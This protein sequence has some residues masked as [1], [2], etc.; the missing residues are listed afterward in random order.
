MQKITYTSDKNDR[1]DSYLQ[2]RYP[3]LSFSKICKY[4]KENKIKVNGKKQPL[5]YRLQNNDEITLFINDL[6]DSTAPL[7]KFAKNE[8]SIQYEDENILIVNKPQGLICIDSNNTIADTLIN[9]VL[10]Y[11]NYDSSFAFTPALCHRLDT[12][13][14]GLV[15]IAKTKPSYDEIT[16]LIKAHKIIKEYRCITFG[17]PK[18]EHDI[19]NTYLKKD[20]KSGFVKSYSNPI[21][22]SLNAISEYNVIATRNT[23]ALVNVKLFTGRT[24]QIR[25]HLSSINCPIIGDTKYGN[26]KQNNLLKLSRQCLVAYKITFPELTINKNLSKKTIEIPT[27]NIEQMFSKL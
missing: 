7:Y 12:G 5:S 13:T 18:K 9:R 16:N 11:L 3:S 10:N 21:Q 2:N 15:I 26:I 4:N 14:E 20:S 1:L 6:P 24:H 19:L 23:Y 27:N 8:L 25:V 22:G 17:I